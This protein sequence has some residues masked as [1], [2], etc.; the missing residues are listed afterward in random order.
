MKWFSGIIRRIQS[1]VAYRH[2]SAAR[3]IA[4]DWE[5]ESA[6]V[7]KKLQKDSKQLRGLQRKLESVSES[8]ASDLEQGE[9][10]RRQQEVVVESLRNENKVLQDV[11]VPSLT[12]AGSVMLQRYDTELSLLVKRQVA[13]TKPEE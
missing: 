9:S 12:A 3:K 7:S 2:L 1:G 13:A 11:L 8:I 5:I 6:I 10:L 4:V